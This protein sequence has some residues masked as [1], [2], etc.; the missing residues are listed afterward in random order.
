MRSAGCIVNDIADRKLDRQVERTKTRPLANND[1]TPKEAL[2]LLVLLLGL[3]LLIAITLGKDIVWLSILWL[4][5]VIL[6]PFMK[7]ITWWPQAF[8]GLTFNAGAIFGWIAIT[9]HITLAP[10]FLYLGGI[11]WTIGYDTLYAIQDMED[12]AHIGIKS[13]ARLFGNH[14][15][16]EISICYTLFMLCLITVGILLHAGIGF[17]LFTTITA[18]HLG[19]QIKRMHTLPHERHG[20]LFSANIHT[21][22][23]VFLAFCADILIKTAF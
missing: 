5:L 22:T 21:G 17:Y 8:L 2:F 23:L 1:I 20:E 18:M 16:R 14:A 7:R 15:S 4:P 9:H 19:W 3:S 10:I 13:T 6:Y 11:F 12:D